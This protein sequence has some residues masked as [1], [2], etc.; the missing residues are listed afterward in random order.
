MN[1]RTKALDAM[2]NNPHG[3]WRIDDLLAVAKQLRIDVRN[4]GGSHHVFSFPGVAL[5]PC[6]PAHRPIKPV[7]VRQFLELVKMIQEINHGNE[8]EEN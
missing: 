3:D 7:Y 8:R 6:V 4:D 2:R 5:A 1:K